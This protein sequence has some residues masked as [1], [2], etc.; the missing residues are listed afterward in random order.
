MS[1]RLHRVYSSK[2]LRGFKAYQISY[3]ETSRRD[4]TLVPVYEYLVPTGLFESALAKGGSEQMPQEAAQ[5][6]N[7]KMDTAL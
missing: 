6:L 1:T 2:A 7:E 3:A 4:G 5:I